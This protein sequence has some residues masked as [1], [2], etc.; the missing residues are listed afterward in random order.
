MADLNNPKVQKIQ[1]SKAFAHLATV[2]PDGVPHSSPMWFLWDGPYIKFTTTPTRQKYRNIQRDPQVAVSIT[3]V[4]DP[5][6]AAEFRGRVERIEAD[7]AGAFYDTLAKHYG[8]P[9]GYQGDPRV[10][11]YMRIRHIAG[12]NLYPQMA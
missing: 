10:I 2:G 5:Y 8:V 6:T 3:D 11:L 7:P 12:Q 9:W 4:D 1:R